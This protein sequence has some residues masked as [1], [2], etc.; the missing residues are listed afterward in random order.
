MPTTKTTKT[1]KK[2]KEL[3][4][5]TI[6]RKHNIAVGVDCGT[7]TGIATA[8]NKKLTFIKTFKI[9]QALD[10]IKTL[11]VEETIVIIEDARLRKNYPHKNLWGYLRYG[12]K[13]NYKQYQMLTQ[14]TQGAGSVKRD[15]AIW[16]DFCKTYGYDYELVNPDDGT[17]KAAGLVTK[18]AQKRYKKRTSEHGRDAAF[19]IRRFWI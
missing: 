4:C 15:A 2:A 9:F 14:S 3:I 8:I 19:L 1:A 17:G 7:K 11:P 5:H 10:Y 16:E 6:G 18:E 12:G 13:I